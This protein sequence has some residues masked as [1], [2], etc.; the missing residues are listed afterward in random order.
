MPC[1]FAECSVLHKCAGRRCLTGGLSE[2]PHAACCA[3]IAGL[4][5][6][7]AAAL[8]ALGAAAAAS[9][10]GLD[11]SVASHAAFSGGGLLCNAGRAP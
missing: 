8:Q 2:V 9:R 6:E 3:G 10:L 11:S 5:P 7:S 1:F 4:T